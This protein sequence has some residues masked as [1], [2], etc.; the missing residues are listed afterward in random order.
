MSLVRHSFKTVAEL[1]YQSAPEMFS[2]MF[3]SEAIAILTDFVQQSHNPFSHRYVR[4][5]EAEDRIVGIATLLTADELND[6]ADYRTRLNTWQQLRLK[7][8]DYLI[9]NRVVRHNYPANTFYIANLAV[10][11][12]YRGQGIGTQLLQRCIAAATTAEA[13]SI[14]IS[15][16]VHNPRAQKLYESLGFQVIETKKLYLGKTIGSRVLVLPLQTD[17]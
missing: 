7:F 15:V 1:I 11:P 4:V 2:F 13:D 5:A 16:D 17:Q 3:G 12:A 6:K 9:L 14:Y 10:D 8:A